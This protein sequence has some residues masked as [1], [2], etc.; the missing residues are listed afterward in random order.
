MLFVFCCGEHMFLF[1]EGVVVVGLSPTFDFGT[2]Y[3][4]AWGGFGSL[5]QV[6]FY[7]GKLLCNAKLFILVI[8]LLFIGR[9]R[10]EP[11]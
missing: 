2:F 6:I 11:I 1:G 3:V 9:F 4:G 8:V 10:I 5:F 7:M